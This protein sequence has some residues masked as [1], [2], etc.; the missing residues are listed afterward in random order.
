MEHGAS[1]S[2]ESLT[3]AMRKDLTKWMAEALKEK[4]NMVKEKNSRL[5]RW[6]WGFPSGALRLRL[7]W[8]KKGT[9]AMAA[10]VPPLP[11]CKLAVLGR[12]A[13][14]LQQQSRCISVQIV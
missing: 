11:R 4:D 9:M 5:S 8:L 10:A 12:S 7:L 6:C 14:H 3:P 13:R 1:S 2:D